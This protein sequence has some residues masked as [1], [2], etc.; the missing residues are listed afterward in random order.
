MTM[1]RMTSWA[2]DGFSD[3]DPCVRRHRPAPTGRGN[4]GTRRI[5]QPMRRFAGHSNI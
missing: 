1:R 5:P 4:P 3:R 2:L